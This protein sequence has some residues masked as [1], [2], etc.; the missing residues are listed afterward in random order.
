LAAGLRRS[1]R[2]AAIPFAEAR[3]GRDEVVPR[4]GEPRHL[5]LGGRAEGDDHATRPSRGNVEPEPPLRAERVR[6][7]LID[8]AVGAARLEVDDV[9]GRFGVRADDQV[10]RRVH[11][12]TSDERV[13]QHEAVE[14][15][16]QQH[17]A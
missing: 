16:E 5:I 4:D 12:D 15:V 10:R 3:L 7:H 13:I 9:P 1:S 8:H 2:L 17:V 11:R 14:G 6:Q